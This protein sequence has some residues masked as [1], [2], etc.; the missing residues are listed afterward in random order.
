MSELCQR[1]SGEVERK[2]C[3][4]AKETRGHV[5]F[6]HVHED[7]WPHGDALEGHVV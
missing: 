3:R 5:N 2:R 1:R 7:P 4:R 6:P